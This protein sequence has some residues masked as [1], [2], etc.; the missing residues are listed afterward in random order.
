MFAVQAFV[1][2]DLRAYRLRKGLSAR[3]FLIAAGA[4]PGTFLAE[5]ALAV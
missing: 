1:P 5:Q 2:S 3:S 4:G